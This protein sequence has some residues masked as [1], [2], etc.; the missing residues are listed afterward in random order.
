MENEED[1]RVIRFQSAG[2]VP[3]EYQ[4]VLFVL[5]IKRTAGTIRMAALLKIP[6]VLTRVLEHCIELLHKPTPVLEG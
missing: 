3:R 6:W 4:K 2:N 1:W 5:E